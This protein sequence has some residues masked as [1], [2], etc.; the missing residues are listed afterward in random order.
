MMILFA[1]LAI[2]AAALAGGARAAEPVLHLDEPALMRALEDR[3]FAFPVLFA[4][5]S[6][7]RLGALSASSAAYR[8]IVDVIADDVGALRSEMEA[9]GRPL[10]EVTDGN[11]G[12]VMD[13]RWLSNDAAAFRLAGV[14][15]RLDRRD[16]TQLDGLADCGEVRFVYRLAYD[17]RK[18]TR[19][20][21]S[22]LPFNF[23]AVHA[24]LPDAGGG[25]A[26]AS[27]R[28]MRPA[29][30]KI[31]PDWLLAGPLDPSRL[32]FR[33]LELN[34]QVVRFPSGQET[35]FGGQAAYLLRIFGL[36][37]NAMRELPLE[38]TPDGALLAS[39]PALRQALLDYVAAEGKVIAGGVYRLPDQFLARK[40]ISYSTYGS[41][42]LANRP[43]AAL[44]GESE[45]AAIGGGSLPAGRALV[46]RLD[47]GS[48]QGC[49]QAGSTAGFHLIG[50][51]DDAV[52]PLNR[53]LVGISPHMRA[54]LK[55]RQAWTRAVAEGA[56]PN[57]YRPVSS[58]PPADWD[59]GGPAYEPA[60]AGMACEPG[61][62]QG[63]GG[64]SCRAGTVCTPIATASGSGRVMGQC[65][66]PPGG[67]TMYSGH[68]CLEGVLQDNARHPYNDS[69]TIV[70]QFAAMAPATTHNSY[71]CRPPRIGVPGG[72]AYRGCNDRDRTFA[73]FGAG[74]PMPNE[75]CGLAGG[76]AFD[77]CVATN[78]FDRCLGGAVVRGNRQACSAERP[79]REDYMCQQFPADTPG[80]AKISG[81]GFCSPTYFIFQMRIDN[82][83]APW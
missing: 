40:A 12:R 4:Q 75:I 52:S 27:Q 46:D 58:A 25:C 16:L 54:E 81:I 51:D 7:T 3:G 19:R 35:G 9:A 59:E 64:W 76:K 38:N 57:R 41:I 83:P 45:I 30:M 60:G 24:I 28:W 66:E 33:Q 70:R 36:T 43:F 6:G 1:M 42:R 26:G 5:D 48:C 56:E 47:N 15:N 17:F 34:A 11:V 53:I 78:D 32:A 31:D 44:F 14:V 82:H 67:R 13:L 10:F 65:L 21:T 55:R 62:G 2:V 50:R 18:G 74:K 23:N 68:P 77:L 22:R 8:A 61:T 73:A 80:I 63:D 72:L 71:T 69:L 79:C 39:D 29:D 20:L 49:H 37:G